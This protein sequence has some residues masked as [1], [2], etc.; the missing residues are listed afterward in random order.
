[1]I[2]VFKIQ[3]AYQYPFFLCL[4]TSLAVFCVNHNDCRQYHIGAYCKMI[5]CLCRAKTGPPEAYIIDSFFGAH[6]INTCVGKM[7]HYN[8]FYLHFSAYLERTLCMFLIHLLFIF[9]YYFLIYIFFKRNIS[10]AHIR[11]FL[12]KFLI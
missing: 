7:F 6:K 1:M 11:C 2:F 9:F 10:R 3:L 8:N 4:D 5:P 12:L